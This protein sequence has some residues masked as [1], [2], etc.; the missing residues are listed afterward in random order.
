MTEA[1][2]RYYRQRASAGSV[3]G[4]ARV[5]GF[6]I[7]IAPNAD[8]NADEVFIP[9][10]VAIDREAGLDRIVGIGAVLDEAGQ[11]AAIT[12]QG[13]RSDPYFVDMVALTDAN[14]TGIAAGESLTVDC[15]VDQ[16]TVRSG[17]A[18]L[19]GGGPQLR[20]LLPESRDSD[21]ATARALDLDCDQHDPTDDDCDDLRAA[22]HGGQTEL[23]DGLDTNC[24][25]ERLE[26]LDCALQPGTCGPQASTGVQ[27]CVDVGMGSAGQ[28]VGD[29]RCQCTAGNPGECD[30]CILDFKPTVT[31][32]EQ[33]P[34]A[35]AA[36]AIGIGCPVDDPCTV[37][38]LP[39]GGPWEAKLS[40]DPTSGFASKV[41][42]VTAAVNLRV[43]LESG[44]TITAAPT[45]SVGFV[46]L[47]ITNSTGTHYRGIDL[48]L[49]NLAAAACT[50]LGGGLRVMQCSGP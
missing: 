32:T 9:F 3:D 33:E 41:S 11:P 22:F 37:E 5:D 18:W 2:A 16:A 48:E 49:S 26:L 19:P 12:I 31:V 40:L 6:V 28:C 25:G 45:D 42:G 35:P 36:D 39:R 47:A 10:L 50:D 27:L 38:V 1:A 21:D 30:K 29:P 17:I 23:C 13:G 20:L 34:C 46:F 24:D 7:R 8:A 43:N 44:N 15:A 14:D 4:V